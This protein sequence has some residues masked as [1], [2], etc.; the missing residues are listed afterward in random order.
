L[1]ELSFI[2]LGRFKVAKI[3]MSDILFAHSFKWR[4]T[5]QN[6][7]NI[8]GYMRLPQVLAVFPVSKSTWWEGVR[9]QRY[10]QP[11]RIAPRITAWRKQDILILLS[12]LE[13]SC[14]K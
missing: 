5:L 3:K 10:P 2:N 12:N 14:F 8:F 6:N 11:I 4:S 9:I 13:N 7:D 1:G